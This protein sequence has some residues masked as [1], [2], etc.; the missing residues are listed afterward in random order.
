MD[1]LWLVHHHEDRVA[2][3]L[4]GKQV[5]MDDVRPKQPVD[6]QQGYLNSKAS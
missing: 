6:V 3:E 4:F 5:D 2:A 1:L